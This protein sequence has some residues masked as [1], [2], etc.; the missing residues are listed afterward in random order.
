MACNHPGSYLLVIESIQGGV[1]IR[2]HPFIANGF[3]AFFS[4]RDIRAKELSACLLQIF[5]RV[6]SNGSSL[7]GFSGTATTGSETGL[8]RIH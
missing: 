4:R 8:N 7:V 1:G 3:H 6:E 2:S 5:K